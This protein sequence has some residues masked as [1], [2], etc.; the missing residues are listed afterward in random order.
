MIGAIV[1]RPTK[2]APMRHDASSLLLGLCPKTNL[3]VIYLQNKGRKL[4]QDSR[5]Q[6]VRLYRYFMHVHY[7]HSW[8]RRGGGGGLIHSTGSPSLC[9]EYRRLLKKAYIHHCHRT[10][11]ARKKSSRSRGKE[12]QNAS[13]HTV[14]KYAPSGHHP[15]ACHLYVRTCI[16]ANSRS[17]VSQRP[18][19]PQALIASV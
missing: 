9:G 11:K 2:D 10:R 13:S 15:R 17:A 5:P 16:S 18:S 19:L 14:A 12:T 3:E 4:R 1:T 6:A 7:H 8:A